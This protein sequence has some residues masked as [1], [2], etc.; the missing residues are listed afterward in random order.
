MFGFLAVGLAL[1]RA[2]D[3]VEADT[4]RALVVRDFDGVVVGDVGDKAGGVRR[5]APLLSWSFFCSSGAL[6]FPL[7]QLWGW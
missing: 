1:L 5:S 2:V 4:F 7:G 6:T 3:T